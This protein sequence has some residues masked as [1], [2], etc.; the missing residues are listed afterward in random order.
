MAKFR[1]VGKPETNHGKRIVKVERPGEWPPPSIEEEGK[2]IVH[3]KKLPEGFEEKLEKASEINPKEWYGD[4][5]EAFI[6]DLDSTLRRDEKRLSYIL[7][8]D[9]DKY[10]EAQVN[11]KPIRAT[12]AILNALGIAG[13]RIIILTGSKR[14]HL[15]V[16]WLEKNNVQYD[17][18]FYRGDEDN[19]RDVEYKNEIY[20]SKIFPKYTVIGVFEDRERVVNMWESLGLTCLQPRYNQEVNF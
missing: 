16:A 14:L 9:W 7:E 1:Q 8:N 13:Y 18:L 10:Y 2:A 15:I 12:V 19:T 20:S 3:E 4:R 5:P 11:D 17:E 6:F